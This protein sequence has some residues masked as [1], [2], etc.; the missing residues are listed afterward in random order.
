MILPNSIATS[1]IRANITKIGI[2]LLRLA[3][4]FDANIKAKMNI[5]TVAIKQTLFL[6]KFEPIILALDLKPKTDITEAAE[7]T[8]KHAVLATALFEAHIA[9]AISETTAKTTLCHIT[10]II[11]S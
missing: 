2:E 4:K 7:K 6:I 1:G 10:L 11:C 5:I 8:S 3:L 9:Y